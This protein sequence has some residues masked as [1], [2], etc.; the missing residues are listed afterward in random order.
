MRDA[1]GSGKGRMLDGVGGRALLPLL[2]EEE[3][4]DNVGA[5]S[6]TPRMC[7]IPAPSCV[8]SSVHG[9]DVAD[10]A[11]DTARAIA[12]VGAAECCQS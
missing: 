3:C 10:D 6:N 12:G 9:L 7:T 4:K 2:R 5:G 1:R 8:S 11:M